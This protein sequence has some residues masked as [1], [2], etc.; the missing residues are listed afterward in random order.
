MQIDGEIKNA[1]RKFLWKVAK[2]NCNSTL[3][4]IFSSASFKTF[5]GQRK[6]T[7]RILLK[8]LCFILFSKTKTFLRFFWHS[9]ITVT[10]STFRSWKFSES[11]SWRKNPFAEVGEF[12]ATVLTKLW[13]EFCPRYLTQLQQQIKIETAFVLGLTLKNVIFK[14]TVMSFSKAFCK[15]CSHKNLFIIFHV[16][17]SIKREETRR[18][19]ININCDI[20]HSI[21]NCKYYDK[22]EW[23]LMIM[24]FHFATINKDFGRENI[25]TTGS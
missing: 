25:T 15:F 18:K 19:E 22:H 14:I 4:G 2:K 7:N 24:F 1:Q 23:K 20:S 16:C 11:Y 9:L 5:F 21:Q 3:Q 17:C 8:T 10:C 6:L 13:S 12:S